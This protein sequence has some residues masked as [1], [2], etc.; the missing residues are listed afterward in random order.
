[1]QPPTAETNM[2]NHSKN[3]GRKARKLAQHQP[4]RR[5]PAGGQDT[6]RRFAPGG[7]ETPLVRLRGSAR[8][9]PTKAAE[10][11]PAQRSVRGKKA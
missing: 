8:G 4:A 2:A 6:A 7:D 10:P 5:I 1:M 3:S 11:I 9:G